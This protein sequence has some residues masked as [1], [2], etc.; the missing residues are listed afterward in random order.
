MSSKTQQRPYKGQSLVDF[1]DNYVVIDI[2]TTGLN[3]LNS[4]IIEVACLKIHDNQI[5][6]T[7][8]SLCQPFNDISFFIENLTGITS[9]DLTSAPSP[10]EVISEFVDFSKGYT[11]V[12][13]NINFDI[14]F[15][16]DYCDVYSERPLSND[17]VDTL[18][19]A[20]QTRLDLE[21]YKL[22]TLCSYFN[23][24]NI[25]AHR[26]LSDCYATN[27][28]YQIFKSTPLDSIGEPDYLS[29]LQNDFTDHPFYSKKCLCYE[30]SCI[31]LTQ[32]NNIL[33]KI[34][35][36]P[37]YQHSK[38]VDYIIMNERAMRRHI[39]CYGTDRNFKSAQLISEIEFYELC[40]L[41]V[42]KM[43][44][45]KSKASKVNKNKSISISEII[46]TNTEFDVNH[47]LFGKVCVFTGA[48]SLP[49]E[50]LMQFVV[51]HG[52]ICGSG[53]TK[54]TNYLFVGSFE[55]E[56]RLKGKKSSKIL[57][58]EQYISEGLDLKILS[59][60]EFIDMIKA[61]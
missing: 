49:R 28:L 59:E 48:L 24:H 45:E 14:N 12:G 47:P 13:H 50:E 37:R 40:C 10:C 21:N 6:N 46:P 3:P 2:E 11:L 17:F 35:A 30:T 61:D 53:I 4:E 36:I 39:E 54:K 57:K 27:E 26:A 60:R 9:S 44:K 7:F 8:E 55:N 32:F 51:D 38:S 41:P 19:L 43:I 23:I 52:G 16:Y 29:M 15:L 34:G 5:V 33:I 58:A 22:P 25:N 31:S 1:P 20:R 56:T 42:E 18:R